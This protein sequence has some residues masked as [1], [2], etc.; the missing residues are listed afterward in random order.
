MKQKGET[1]KG[2]RYFPLQV[3]TKLGPRFYLGDLLPSIEN[4]AMVVSGTDVCVWAKRNMLIEQEPVVASPEEAPPGDLTSRGALMSAAEHIAL[5]EA[6][7][8][9]DEETTKQPWELGGA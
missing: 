8:A 3:I 5:E 4:W 1:K 6:G 7:L 9:P 2:V